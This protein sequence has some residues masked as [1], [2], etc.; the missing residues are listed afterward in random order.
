MNLCPSCR[1]QVIAWLITE[2]SRYEDLLVGL[3]ATEANP[4]E[5]TEAE[6]GDLLALLDAQ[7]GA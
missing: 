6:A 1:A 4:S 2:K 3:A 7:S 5:L